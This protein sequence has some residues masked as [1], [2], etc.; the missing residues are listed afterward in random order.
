MSADLN[1][2]A[3]L[4]TGGTSGIGLATAALLLRRGAKVA[5]NGRDAAR[6]RSAL[7]KLRT[8]SKEVVFIQGD[9][10][11]HHDCRRIVQ[12]TAE[13]FGRLDIV[14]NSAGVYLEK[15]IADTSETELQNVMATN[16]NGPYF[17][18]KFAAPQMR[19]AGGGAIINIAS[20]AGLKGNLACTAYCAAKGA[21]VAFTKALALELAPYGIR[22]NCVCPGDVATAMLAQQLSAAPDFSQ[23]AAI[24]GL[25]PLG[26]VAQPEE[27]AQV[28]CF[29]ASP[30]ASYVTGAIWTVDGGLTAR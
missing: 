18:A 10:S 24:N 8:I 26:R 25:Y 14:V 5:V 15:L 27:V 28:I 11:R 7:A 12:K 30:A 13:R 1:G 22:V 16:I 23:S 21:V 4:I 20:D 6:G 29:L 17:I 19:K 9:V 3:A 2:Q